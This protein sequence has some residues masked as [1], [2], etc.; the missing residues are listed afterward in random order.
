MN[1]NHETLIAFE[2]GAHGWSYQ[3]VPDL[4]EGPEEI[5]DITLASPSCDLHFFLLFITLL[6]LILQGIRTNSHNDD[7]AP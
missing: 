1:D 3:C 2:I 4:H 7:A 6:I 5:V